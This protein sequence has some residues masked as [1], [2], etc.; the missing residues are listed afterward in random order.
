MQS[1]QLLVE[2]PDI[3]LFVLLLPERNT[4]SLGFQR[5][6]VT[7]GFD[8]CAGP[9]VRNRPPAPSGPASGAPSGRSGIEVVQDEERQGARDR[10]R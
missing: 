3:E 5:T 10:R 7:G 1:P 2:V 4:S 9:P 8:R 6:R